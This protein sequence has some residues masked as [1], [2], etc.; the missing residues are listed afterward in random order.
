MG[1]GAVRGFKELLCGNRVLL[2]LGIYRNVVIITFLA[3]LLALIQ[4]LQS[5]CLR[6]FH[7]PAV[8]TRMERKSL[9]EL[10]GE[11]AALMVR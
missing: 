10:R 3:S 4:G 1:G 2:V 8:K 7:I 6:R 9:L 5:H 11:T